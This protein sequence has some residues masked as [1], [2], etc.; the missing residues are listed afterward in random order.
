MKD[1]LDDRLARTLERSI[2]PRERE[3]IRH[4]VEEG[5]EDA[6]TRAADR[7]AERHGAA[8][9]VEP[10]R[11]EIEDA[12]E[13]HRL[14]GERLVELA[15]VVVGRLLALLVAE[16][17]HR[18]LGRHHHPLGRHA[19]GLVAG[20][21]RERGQPVRLRE[22]LVRHD[23]RRGAVVDRRGVAGRSRGNGDDLRHRDELHARCH[24]VLQP[25]PERG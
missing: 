25:D 17:L 20:D 5:R 10:L 22:L 11:I 9:H 24:H 6:C 16:L 12:R 13:G 4:R 18:D 1:E 14:R 15:D 23:E 7:V 19:A 3:L 2:R 8:V 21:L